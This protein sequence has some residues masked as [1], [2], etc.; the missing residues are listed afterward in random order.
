[1]DEIRGVLHR[2]EKLPAPTRGVNAAPRRPASGLTPPS[3]PFHAA[4][5]LPCRPPAAEGGPRHPS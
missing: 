3:P 1:A 2:A 5:L 4:D